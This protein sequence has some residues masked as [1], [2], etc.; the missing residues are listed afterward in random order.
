MQSKWISRGKCPS[1]G[2][3][4]GYNIHA[5]GHAFCFS[6]QKRFNNVGEAKMENK[7][8]EIPSKV[9]STG[10]YGSISDRRI[11]EQTARKYRT[12]IK[13]NGSVISHHYYE[14]Y[15]ADGSHVATKV[16]QVEGKRIWSQ[17]DMGDALL[18]GQNLFKSGGKYITITEG[19]IDAMSTY[20]MLGSKWAVV[21]IKNGVQSAV[22]NVKQHL[23][24][25]IVLK[26]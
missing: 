3:S 26:M 4:N 15:N 11:S 14:Y 25:L 18:F 9:S 21:S 2:S 1:C 24:Y 16:R 10:D 22:H 13:T 5:D 17:G 8:V 6:C 12:K 7:V 23:K 20:E 19:E